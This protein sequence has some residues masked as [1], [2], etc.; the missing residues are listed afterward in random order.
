MGEFQDRCA[1]EFCR[2]V[3]IEWERKPDSSIAFIVHGGT[4]MAIL[5]RF[6]H[7][8]KSYYEWQTENG[9]GYAAEVSYDESAGKP[10]LRHIVDLSEFLNIAGQRKEWK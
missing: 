8:H 7:P 6:S 4:I 1:D 2:V 5:D 9:N 3:D 10:L